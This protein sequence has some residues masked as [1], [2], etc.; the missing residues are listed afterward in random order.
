MPTLFAVTAL[1][2]VCSVSL[3]PQ[4]FAS[5]VLSSSQASYVIDLEHG[6]S[7]SGAWAEGDPSKTNLINTADL[8]RYVQVMPEFILPPPPH[9]PHPPRTHTS[10]CFCLFPGKLL[11]RPFTL[12]QLL[13]AQPAVA[14]E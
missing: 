2:L 11:R 7:V 8:G 13:L 6:C 5:F 1:L 14:V 4:S 12:R 10:Q 3:L 9:P